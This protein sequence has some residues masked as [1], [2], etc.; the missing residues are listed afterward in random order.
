MNRNGCPS[1]RPSNIVGEVGAR[2]AGAEHAGDVGVGRDECP[3]DI[4]R[5]DIDLGITGW[6]A[7][8][9]EEYLLGVVVRVQE[10][11]GLVHITITE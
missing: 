3:V 11:V 8:N 9:T 5:T 7:K 10:G 2:P 1:R 6:P 4:G